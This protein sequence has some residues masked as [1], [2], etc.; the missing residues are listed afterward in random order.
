MTSCTRRA[1]RSDSCCIRPANRRTASGS[2]AASVSASAS[3]DIAPTGVLSSWLTFATKSRRTA[4]TRRASVRS[5]TS[6]RTRVE[7]SGATRAST[8]RVAEPN[9][10]RRSS[11]SASR[12]SPSRRTARTS[13]SSSSDSSRCSR[14]RPKEYAAGLARTTWSAASRTTV[15]DRSS[16]RTS[17]TPAGSACGAGCH[18][19]G[20]L[21]AL[22]GPE[23]EHRAAPTSDADQPATSPASNA[24][25]PPIVG[26]PRGPGR[27]PRPRARVVRLLFTCGQAPVHA[28]LARCA[29]VRPTKGDPCATRTTRSSTPSPTSWSR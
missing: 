26:A 19:D 29:A 22:A 17:A 6:T 15:E 2:S 24:S 20:L 28:R 18:V 25:T 1:S 9:G 23:R 27:C 5:S 13:S 12:I 4:S 3:S 16:A 10:P 7:P 14:T 11:S 21:V 8:S